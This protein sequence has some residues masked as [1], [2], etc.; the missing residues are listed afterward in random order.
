VSNLNR[1]TLIGRLTRDPEMR[2]TASGQ[3][4]TSFGLA[5]NHFMRNQAGERT[6]LTDFHNIVC[7]N[8]GKRLLAEQASKY[9]RKGSLCYVEGRLSTREW[10]GQDGVKRR[11]TEIVASD[12]QFLEP[13]QDSQERELFPPLEPALAQSPDLEEIPF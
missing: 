1:A 10:E 5:T 2:Y 8:I 7:W 12:V 4:V 3:P 11:Q 6:E 9:L 13:R